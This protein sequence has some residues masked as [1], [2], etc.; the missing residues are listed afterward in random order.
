M[1]TLIWT[2]RII[3]VLSIVTLALSCSQSWAE[4]RIVVDLDRQVVSAWENNE[5]LHE[6]DA[7]TGTCAKWTHPGAYSIY[8]KV[9]DYTSKTYNSP[10]PYTMFFTKDG[11]AIHGTSFA[12]IRSY[13]HAYVTDEVGSKGCVGISDDNAK[14][15]FE[16]AIVGTTVEVLN[17]ARNP[18]EVPQLE[19]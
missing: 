16:W 18:D 4:K 11:K 7:V 3:S 13:L 5:I 14:T 1:P 6:F 12:T 2:H 17:S 8:R 10:M 15:L 19:K 9:E